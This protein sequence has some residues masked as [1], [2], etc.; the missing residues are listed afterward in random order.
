MNT[1][2]LSLALFMGL[3]FTL[4]NCGGEEKKEEEA[5]KEDTTAVVEEAPKYEYTYKIEELDVMP[6]WVV[7]IGDTT[8]VDK[9]GP[10]FEKNFPIL[11]KYVTSKKMKAEMPAAY[12]YDFSVDKPFYTLA[13]MYVNDSTLKVKEPMKLQKMPGGKA[14]KV[15]Y[16]GAYEKTE[17]AYNDMMAYMEEKGWMPAGAPWEQYMTDPGMEKDTAKWQTDIYFLVAPKEAK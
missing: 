10:F 17:T 16:F 6:R 14:I 1:K 15:Q 3:S 9:L 11:G 12:Y 8:T 7:A 5:P 4:V 2:F 13:A